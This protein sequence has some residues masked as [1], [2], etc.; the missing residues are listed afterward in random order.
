[1]IL[2][3]GQEV[4]RSCVVI[5]FGR[6]NVMFDCGVHMGR[7]SAQ[8]LPQFDLLGDIN[9]ISNKIDA[10]VITH[11]HLDHIGCLPYL[12]ETLRYRGPIVMTH[13]TRALA[14]LLLED[15]HS[16]CTRRCDTFETFLSSVTSTVASRSICQWSS[17]LAQTFQ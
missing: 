15:Y 4:G 1:M 13:A 3:A 12:T 11:F 6:V 5:S 17:H 2:G 7:H 14:P 10:V 16:I 9:A 8:M